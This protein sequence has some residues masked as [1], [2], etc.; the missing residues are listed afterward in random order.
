MMA[1]YRDSDEM[2]AVGS[3]SEGEIQLPMASNTHDNDINELKIQGE[4][5]LPKRLNIWQLEKHR[6]SHS[7]F[8]VACAF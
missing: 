3:D 4:A 7:Y 5:E 1:R 2:Y 8:W 6:A